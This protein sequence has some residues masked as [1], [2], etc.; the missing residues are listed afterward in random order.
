MKKK[1]EEE[2]LGKMLSH[3]KTEDGWWESRKLW[4]KE[5][6][7]ERNKRPTNE[8]WKMAG[9]L[10]A[11]LEYPSWKEKTNCQE[12]ILELDHVFSPTVY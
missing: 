10:K 2:D 4:E 11:L 12:Y 6:T 5:C 3:W 8:K 7:D 9:W 1:K